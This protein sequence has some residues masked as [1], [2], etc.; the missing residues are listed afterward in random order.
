MPGSALTRRLSNGG[1]Y[2]G[3]SCHFRTAGGGISWPCSAG[4]G[5]PGAGRTGILSPSAG[6]YPGEVAPISL[7]SP[8]IPPP[9]K[10]PAEARQLEEVG[11]RPGR[12]SWV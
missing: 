1:A 9:S 5:G 6:T 12:T 8:W 7:P 11:A 4:A 2:M 10:V 3:Q